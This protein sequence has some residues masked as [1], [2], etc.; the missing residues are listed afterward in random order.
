MSKEL[1]EEALI[2]CSELHFAPDRSIV[3]VGS[4][5]VEGDAAQDGKVLRPV[6]LSGAGVVF[7]KDHVEGPV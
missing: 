6:I 4:Q 5:D 3:G 7:V 1:E 2:P